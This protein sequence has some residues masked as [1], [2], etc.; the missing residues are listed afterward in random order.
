MSRLI[1][2]IASLLATPNGLQWPRAVAPFE[3]ALLVGPQAR[4][5]EAAAVYD[6]LVAAEGAAAGVDVV[7]DDRAAK[8]LG[9]KLK[10]AELIGY[11]V[12]VVMG[13]GWKERR[14]VE[15]QCR[16]VGVKKD[17]K[18][19]ELRGRLR[20]CWRSCRVYGRCFGILYSSSSSS[21]R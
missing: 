18:L 11:P 1:G 4:D 6:G 9:W 2:A 15:V 13:R 5:D 3:A 10:D 12:V 17:V 8:S 21:V 16:R 14:E 19:E 20:D 7:L